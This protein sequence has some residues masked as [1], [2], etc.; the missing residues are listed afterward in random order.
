MPSDIETCRVHHPTVDA[1][2]GWCGSVVNMANTILGAGVLAMPHAIASTGIVFGV[3]TIVFAGFT[4]AMGLYLLS[5][6]ATK[7]ERGQASFFAIANKTYPSAAVIFDIAI[8]LKTFGVG[9]SYL[10]IIGDLMPQISLSIA[11]L[12]DFPVFQDRQFWIT[13][14]MMII[15][16]LSFLR[17]LDSLRYTS[18]I[19]LISVGYLVCTVTAHYIIGDTIQDRG[20]INIIAWKGPVQFISAVPIFVFAYTCHQNVYYVTESRLTT[21]FLYCHKRDRYVDRSFGRPVSCCRPGRIFIFWRQRGWKYY[22]N[23]YGPSRVA[24]KTPDKPSLA[25]TIGRTAIVLLVLFSFPLQAHPCR[26]SLEHIIMWRPQMFLKSHNAAT[27][28]HT[29]SECRFA[30]LT[31]IILVCSYAVSMTVTSLERVL[32]FVGA[33]GSTA[34][35]FILPG[36]FYWKLMSPYELIGQHDEREDVDG[37]DCVYQKGQRGLRRVAL[38]LA[39]YGVFVMVV[40]FTLNLVGV[41]LGH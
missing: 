26:A 37:P 23:V 19:A 5:R 31:S 20:P 9:V 34:I 13:A 28:R 10:I 7:A 16:P 3:A 1:V 40:T 4:S 32:A 38:F 11:G 29:R 2:A 24:A 41:G 18:V 21:D 25:S 33:T 14:C 15:I 22:L 35:S 17:R 39:A 36:L 8:A 27:P 30:L 6:C 12:S